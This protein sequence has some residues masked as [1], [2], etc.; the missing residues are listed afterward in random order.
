[1][2]K[3]ATKKRAWTPEHVRT[4]KALARKKTHAAQ[5][6]KTL[7]RTVGVVASD[8]AP[9]IGRLS[10]SGAH[11]FGITERRALASMGR[12]DGSRWRNPDKSLGF[13]A[14]WKNGSAASALHCRC[15]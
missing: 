1:M 2:A 11:A 10:Q 7:K 5:I 14:D 8:P 3:K 9:C 6:A 4:L 15:A 12:H 13:H